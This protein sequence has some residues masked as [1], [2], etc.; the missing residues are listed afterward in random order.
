MEQVAQSAQN[1]LNR[2][3]ELP[4]KYFLEF[5]KV[6]SSNKFDYIVCIEGNDQPYYTIPCR[7]HLNSEKIYFLRCNGK[8]NLVE[9]IY[10]IEKSTN[11]DY[12]DSNCLGFIDRDYGY[13]AA[14]LYPERIYETPTYSF[15]NFYFSEKC[16]INILESHFNIKEFNDFSKDYAFVLDNFKSRLSEYLGI[17][18]EVDS[19]YRA[20]QISKKQIKE[21]LP[22][23][24]ASNINLSHIEVD[25]NSVQL[26]NNKVLQDCF[27]VDISASYSVQALTKSREFYN[28][29]DIWDLCKFIRGKFLIKFLARYLMRLKDDMNS[30]RETI[31]FQNRQKLRD[32]QLVDRNAFYKATLT[33]D[34]STILSDLAQYADQPECLKSFL[35]GFRDLKMPQAA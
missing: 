24:K 10:T 25:L 16:F 30:S 8:P 26:A 31:C 5:I 12:K 19:L 29:L 33:L 6:H 2:L 14:N 27:R 28:N 7:T 17:V 4:T 15:E 18:K 11:D 13:D 3:E 22:N 9:L 20:T 21:N 1:L 23:Y 35:C 34:E 32:E